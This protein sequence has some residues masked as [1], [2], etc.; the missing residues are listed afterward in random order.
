M[1]TLDETDRALAETADALLRRLA[2]VDNIT[3][4]EADEDP[5]ANALALV[6]ELKVMVPLAGLIDVGAEREP[7][8]PARTR[9]SFRNDR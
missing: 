8:P 9:V 2:K 1:P 3:W 6:G 5:P 4:L 7:L